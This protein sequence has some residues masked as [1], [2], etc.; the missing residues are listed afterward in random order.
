MG[1]GR[2]LSS[3][4]YFLFLLSFLFG[5]HDGVWDDGYFQVPC[6]YV[7]GVMDRHGWR[8]IVWLPR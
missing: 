2:G 7:V 4:S 6:E 8:F 3:F 1:R 5:L